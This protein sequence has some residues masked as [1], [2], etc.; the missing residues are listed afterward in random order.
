MAM[1]NVPEQHAAEA[2]YYLAENHADPRQKHLGE[3]CDEI[4]LHVSEY[5]QSKG[6]LIND[7][8]LIA[9]KMKA[10]YT[11]SRSSNESV[12]KMREMAWQLADGRSLS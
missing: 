9:S 11:A 8:N 12:L 6:I 5:I 4:L 3:L 7:L 2:L 1:S 10:I